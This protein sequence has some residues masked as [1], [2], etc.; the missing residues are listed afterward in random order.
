[1]LEIR[2]IILYYLLRNAGLNHYNFGKENGLLNR[3]YF[4]P[5]GSDLK[6]FTFSEDYNHVKY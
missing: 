2:N 1:V 3:K 6:R 4:Y 5:Q